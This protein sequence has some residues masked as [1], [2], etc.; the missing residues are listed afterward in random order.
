MVK[1]NY[2]LMQDFQ[3]YQSISLLDLDSFFYVV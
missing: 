2:E 1:V 3:N